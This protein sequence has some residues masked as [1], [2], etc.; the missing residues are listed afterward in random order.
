MVVG[1]AA[2]GVRGA[3]PPPARTTTPTRCREPGSSNRSQFGCAPSSCS[4]WS[5]GAESCAS[6][7]SPAACSSAAP[8]TAGGHRH[9]IA[10][11]AAHR[12]AVGAG[13][14]TRRHLVRRHRFAWADPVAATVARFAARRLASPI[15]DIQFAAAALAALAILLAGPLTSLAADPREQARKQCVAAAVASARFMA[16]TRFAATARLA[17]ATRL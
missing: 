2:C 15:V 12:P 16:A 7:G 11:W 13:A 9:R 5:R 4:I 6:A 14:D 3:I 8:R 17:A 1:H 10:R